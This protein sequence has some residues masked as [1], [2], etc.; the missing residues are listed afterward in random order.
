M[1]KNQSTKKSYQ[2]LES[3]TDENILNKEWFLNDYVDGPIEIS[4]DIH[5]WKST[6]INQSEALKIHNYEARKELEKFNDEC[7][8]IVDFI[9]EGNCVDQ[10][11]NIYLE[12]EDS[13]MLVEFYN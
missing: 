11:Y 9:L 2:S 13:K 6:S 10:L 1:S 4:D 7:Q 12:K 8:L 3:S 5:S